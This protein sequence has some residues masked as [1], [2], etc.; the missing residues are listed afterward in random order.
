[1]QAGGGRGYGTAFMGVDGLVALV[2]RPLVVAADVGRKRDVADA[3]EDGIEIVDR[4]EAEEA[5]TEVVALQDFGFEFGFS[6]G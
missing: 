6:G 1:V 2:V 3:V 5:R 4:V